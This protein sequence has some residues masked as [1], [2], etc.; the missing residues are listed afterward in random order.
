M[1]LSVEQILVL[2]DLLPHL[3]PFAATDFRKQ[4]VFLLRYEGWSWD[5]GEC[6]A[7]S[8]TSYDSHT[9]ESCAPLFRNDFSK[10]LYLSP[11]YRRWTKS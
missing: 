1:K 7:S 4:T 11:V 3:L 2:V 10:D 8:P 6:P 5:C 9:C